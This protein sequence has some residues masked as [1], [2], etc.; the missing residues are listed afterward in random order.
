MREMRREKTELPS[1]TW[2]GW[3]FKKGE[4]LFSGQAHPTPDTTHTSE[5]GSVLYLGMAQERWDFAN[6]TCKTILDL[7][8]IPGYSVSPCIL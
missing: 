5:C 2:A 6:F 4:P 7:P 8:T 3:A 1:V